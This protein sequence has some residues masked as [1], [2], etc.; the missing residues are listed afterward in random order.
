MRQHQHQMELPTGSYPTPVV[1]ATCFQEHMIKVSEDKIIVNLMK[2]LRLEQRPR[3]EESFF[4]H[5]A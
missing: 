4:S 1:A 5:E 3:E 2:R